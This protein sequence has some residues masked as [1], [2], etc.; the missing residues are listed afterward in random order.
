MSASKTALVVDCQAA[1]L[2]VV[3]KMVGEEG[4]SVQ[5]VK[6]GRE[7][8]KCLAEGTFNLIVSE[9]DMIPITGM[10]LWRLIR[11]EP[12]HDDCL[13][14]LLATLDYRHH[15]VHSGS[16]LPTILCKPFNR[17]ML[18]KMLLGDRDDEPGYFRI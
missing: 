14:L 3:S 8:L 6:T 1:S 16:E 17:E 18:A 12:R 15:L 4:Y 13:F 5:S 9:H 11:K 7:A 10:D 2:A